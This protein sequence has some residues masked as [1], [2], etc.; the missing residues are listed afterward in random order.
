LSPLLD[1]VEFSGYPECPLCALDPGPGA[2]VHA[3]EQ[4]TTQEARASRARSFSAPGAS[5][6]TG[7]T[8]AYCACTPSAKCACASGAFCAATSVTQLLSREVG[9]FC[10]VNFK[11]L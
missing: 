3:T 10:P 5:C 9:N 8:H 6:A 2:A 11:L 7:A 4:D 1:P